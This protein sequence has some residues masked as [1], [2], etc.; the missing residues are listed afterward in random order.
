MG[1]GL[2]EIF[3]FSSLMFGAH[4]DKKPNS[5][6]K[7]WKCRDSIYK[8]LKQHLIINPI[9]K[10][11]VLQWYLFVASAASVNTMI[12]LIDLTAYPRISKE[13]CK[14]LATCNKYFANGQRRGWVICTDKRILSL[15]GDGKLPNTGRQ[16]SLLTG[17]GQWWAA[18]HH[19]PSMVLTEQGI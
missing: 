3:G 8:S 4:G 10:K 13:F 14:I 19:C 11:T 9:L 18:A 7:T 16:W 12:A 1:C 5:K 17:D 6:V 15:A 2:L